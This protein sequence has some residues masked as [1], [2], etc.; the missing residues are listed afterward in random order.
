[1]NM[2][3]NFVA[4]ALLAGGFAVL[5]PAA[6]ARVSVAIG[7]GYPAYIAPP[8]VV[9]APPAYYTAAPYPPPV[10]VAPGYWWYDRWGHRHWR[11]R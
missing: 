5:A 3:R 8:P 10:V 4:L 6:Q 11:R 2:K 1:M 7:L 9:V